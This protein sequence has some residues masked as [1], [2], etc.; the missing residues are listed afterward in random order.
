MDLRRDGFRI[1]T[2]A[3][4]V[5]RHIM[6]GIWGHIKK[7]ADGS[8]RAEHTTSNTEHR[9]LNAE[10]VDSGAHGVTRP[11]AAAA[12]VRQIFVG[13]KLSRGRL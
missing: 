5:A 10:V 8:Q 1:E 6:E 2:V 9:T 3:K 7:T 4:Q 13:T 12:G 11:L